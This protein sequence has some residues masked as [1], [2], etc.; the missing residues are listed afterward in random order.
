MSLK[1]LLDRKANIH[2]HSIYL[3]KCISENIVPYGP[4]LKNFPHF[5]NPSADFKQNWENTLTSCSKAFMTLLIEEHKKELTQVD[6]E[7]HP[8]NPGIVGLNNS[9]GLVEKERELSDS[10]EMLSRETITKK[11]KKLFKDR[12]AFL[13]NKAYNWPT[14]QPQ[15]HYRPFQKFHPTNQSNKEPVTSDSSVF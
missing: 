9:E 5:R 15:R 7:L 4:R 13:T 1:N 10:L 12:K 6:L 8:L 11:E 2:W 14:F 3:E